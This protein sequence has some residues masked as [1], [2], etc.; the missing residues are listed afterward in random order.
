MLLV[1]LLSIAQPQQWLLAAVCAF[2]AT[3]P[4]LAHIPGFV[5]TLRGKHF[6]GKRPNWYTRFAIKI[7]WF[8]K[9]IG[10]LFEAAWLVGFLVLIAA[11][12]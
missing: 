10:A 3:A 8:E 6:L 4:D 5:R 2:I 12:L 7:Q 1:L 9:P 11:Y